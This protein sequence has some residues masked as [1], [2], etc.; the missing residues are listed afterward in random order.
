MRSTSIADPASLEDSVA[1]E[2][3]VFE[4]QDGPD[5]VSTETL[6]FCGR[7]FGIDPEAFGAVLH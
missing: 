4:V 1:Y 3:T 7:F 2:Q 5:W 6:T